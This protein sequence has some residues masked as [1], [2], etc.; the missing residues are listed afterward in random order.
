MIGAHLQANRATSLHWCLCCSAANIEA[1]ELLR[2]ELEY[3]SIP[4]GKNCCLVAGGITGCGVGG[5]F[6]LQ[7]FGHPDADWLQGEGTVATSRPA[8]E[9][10]SMALHGLGDRLCF[11]RSNARALAQHAAPWMEILLTPNF[12]HLKD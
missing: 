10:K 3:S 12:Y 5:A 1:T 8:A 11:L 9:M 7:T 6:L 2:E 4:E